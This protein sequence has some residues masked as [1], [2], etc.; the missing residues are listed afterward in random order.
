MARARLALAFLLL[1]STTSFPKSYADIS[2]P[3]SLRDGA[4]HIKNSKQTS[5]PADTPEHASFSRT[6][7]TY[8]G[9]PEV[10]DQEKWFESLKFQDRPR[11]QGFLEILD[12]QGTYEREQTSARRRLHGP[13][14]KHSSS[15]SHDSGIPE[16]EPET[17]SRAWRWGSENRA[18]TKANLRIIGGTK[19]RR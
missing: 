14:G 9:L 19:V 12:D 15:Y 18:H 11:L 13:D 16:D 17:T 1:I 2:S 10:D 4:Q 3:S 8:S 5:L 7:K 6:D